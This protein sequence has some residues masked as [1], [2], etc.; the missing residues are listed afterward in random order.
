MYDA[1][2]YHL[3]FVVRCLS[4]SIIIVVYRQTYLVPTVIERIVEL[5]ISSDH[6]ADSL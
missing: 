5:S 3:Y 2:C 1:V 6:G 4:C